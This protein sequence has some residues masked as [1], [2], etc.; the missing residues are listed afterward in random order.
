MS[1]KDAQ[2]K[3]KDKKG[4][5]AKNNLPVEKERDFRQE[6]DD[7]EYIHGGLELNIRERKD[8]TERQCEVLNAMIGKNTRGI[9]LDA[10]FGT[11]KSH[12]AVLAALKL[13]N[14][15][16][17]KKVI[18]V[19]S[20]VESGKSIGFQP[21]TAEEK[22]AAWN[23]VLFDKLAELLPAQEAKK[24]IEAKI[25]DTIVPAFIRGRS[26]DD[27]ILLCDE[28]SCFTF[29]EFILITSRI[30]KNSRV[31][32]LGDDFQ[33]DIKNSGFEKYY[34]AFDNENSRRNGMFCFK[35]KEE[36]DI[37]RSGFM[38]FCMIQLGVLK[39]KSSKALLK[40]GDENPDQR[41]CAAPRDFSKGEV[42]ECELTERP[43]E[44]VEEKSFWARMRFW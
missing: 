34:K 24:L 1:K 18:Y 38:K 13:L 10:L 4:K 31:Y 14:S 42:E 2:K 40:A 25:V 3:N 28:A 6:R 36:S 11:G 19:R 5:F 17:I 26:Y 9:V 27:T 22:C 43:A 35:L 12:M 33:S 30:G 21:G 37:V 32:F 39:F 44:S 41:E 8:Y 16:D 23:A 7:A 20:P 15:G 29:E